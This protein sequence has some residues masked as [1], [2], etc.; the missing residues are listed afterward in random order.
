MAKRQ[1]GSVRLPRAEPFPRWS[2]HRIA[3]LGVVAL[4][5]WA[6]KRHYADAD[7]AALRWILKPVA[8]LSALLGGTSF[9]W[10]PGSGY[11]SREKLL[12]IA[13]PCAGVNFLLAALGMTG[14]LL[15]E[16]AD[17]WRRA[18]RLTLLAA[19]M[20]YAATLIANTARIVIAI[21][22][23]SHPMTTAFWTAARVHRIEGVVVYFAALVALHFV[24]RWFTSSTRSDAMA[25]WLLPLASYYAVTIAVPLVNGAGVTN[26]V[27]LEHMIAV[28]LVPLTLVGIV[29]AL[30]YAA[31][32]VRR[33]SDLHRT[34]GCGRSKDRYRCVER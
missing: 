23:S 25:A 10:E 32:R 30:Q 14:F 16:R 22:L 11:L 31:T 4:T 34:H 13:K 18:L 15:A 9:D 3:M 17:S 8:D 19:A 5:I 12:V 20:A 7:V 1:D 6:L 29:A 28:S 33:R 27:F 2:G 26:R 21:W 24:L